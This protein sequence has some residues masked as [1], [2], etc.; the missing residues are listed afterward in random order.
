MKK[1]LKNKIGAFILVGC[2]TTTTFLATPATLV[3]VE[4]KT[5]YVYIAASGKGTKY[6][7]NKNCS[8]MRGNVKKLK[9][10]DAKKSGYGAC[11]KCY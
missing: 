4:S 11:K 7:S 1:L 9:L 10:S 8:R 6:H 5:Q 2:I 3:Q